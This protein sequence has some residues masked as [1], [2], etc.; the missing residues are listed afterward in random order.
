[1]TTPVPLQTPEPAPEPALLSARLPSLRSRLAR[2]V[3]LPLALVWLA[4]TAITT[5]V[6]HFYA[7]QAFDRALLD[8]AYALAANVQTGPQGALLRL[9]ESELKALLFDQSESVYFAVRRFDGSLVSGHAWLRAPLPTHT[10][11]PAP[12]AATGAT[13]A[14]DPAIKISE[15]IEKRFEFSDTSHQ[16]KPLRVVSVYRP[17]ADDRLAFQVVMAQTTH[18]R[19]DLLQRVLLFSLVP[20]A[21][22]LLLLAWWLRRAIGTD[23]HPLAALQRALDQRDTHDLAPVA[24]QASTRDL[25]QLGGALNSLMARVE[26]GVRAQREFAGNV[27]HEL[28][29]PLAGIRA[30][31]EYGLAQANPQVWQQQLIAVSASE[32]RASHMVTQLLALALADETRDSLRLVP[33]ALDVL[34]R[35]VVL[36]AMPRADALGVDLG[37]RGIDE[38][39][40]VHGDVGLIEGVLNNLLDNALRYGKPTVGT[41]PAITV[42]LHQAAG[43]VSLR[44]IDNGPGIAAGQRQ[45]MVRRW[46]RAGSGMG[47]DAGV[48]TGSGVGSGVGTGPGAGM[49]AQQGVGFGVGLGLAI[50]ARYAA[51]LGARFELVNG[52]GD[53]SAQASTGTGLCAGLAWPVENRALAAS[54]QQAV[55]LHEPTVADHQRLPGQRV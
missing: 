42:A 8:D 39:V 43:A 37:A 45:D 2:H 12:A 20:Q 9:T 26:A 36:Q 34:V 4:G 3:L 46:Q 22:L 1:M 29:T 13:R 21:I 15:K 55:S 17:A 16:G 7:Q 30:L 27:A 32:A 6:A 24:V 5:S 31:A 54:V 53:S 28:R 47:I 40:T 35:R 44:V 49:E 11:N 48:G 23:L 19:T 38:P 41:T 25:Q 51:L 14:P 52:P 33:V 18:S 10:P 50:V